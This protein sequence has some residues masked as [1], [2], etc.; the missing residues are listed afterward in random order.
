VIDIRSVAESSELERW[1]GVRRAPQDTEEPGDTPLPHSEDT[2]AVELTTTGKELSRKRYGVCCLGQ[3][4]YLQSHHPHSWQLTDA[5]GRLQGVRIPIGRGSVTIVNGLLI[6]ERWLL[7]A[8]NALLFCDVVQLRRGDTIYFLSDANGPT[9]L[10]IVWGTGW[11]V[12]ALAA[13]LLVL[14]LWRRGLRFGPLEAPR[15]AAR[16]SLAE[17]IRGTG[18]FMIR[19]GSGRALHAASVR[20]LHEI[21]A[22]RVQGYSRLTQP[23]RVMAVQR[24]TGLPHEE[25]AHAL[26]DNP[27]RRRRELYRALALLESARRMLASPVKPRAAAPIPGRESSH[28]Q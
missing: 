17:Q 10:G 9:L 24:S 6:A 1:A 25:L 16:R 19:Y 8:D 3:T 22:Q 13:A 15:Q 4:T 11:P 26:G 20:A 18:Q 14:F 12:L 27:P 28:A 5:H 23:E 21:A 7:V 2:V